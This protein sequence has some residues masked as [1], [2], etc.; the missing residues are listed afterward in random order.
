MGHCTFLHIYCI[1]CAYLCIFL[2]AYFCNF[3]FAY[4]CTLKHK[5]H[6]VHIQ[7]YN[8]TFPFCIFLHIYAYYYLHISSYCMHI[9]LENPFC[10][11][12]HIYVYFWIFPAYLQAGQ[13]WP[14]LRQFFMNKTL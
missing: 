6:T 1:F 12:L 2:I 14:I 8:C 13:F 10:I 11:L 4:I 9:P 7:A 5:V 3:L